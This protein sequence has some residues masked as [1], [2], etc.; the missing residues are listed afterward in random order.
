MIPFGLELQ[1][2]SVRELENVMASSFKTGDDHFCNSGNGN[3]TEIKL[4]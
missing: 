3:C 1:I 4:E 2:L